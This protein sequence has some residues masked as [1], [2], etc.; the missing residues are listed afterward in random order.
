A[1][2]TT[3]Q[4]IYVR[5]LAP[6]F[7]SDAT[8]KHD[9]P[10]W[11]QTINGD[12]AKFWPVR[13]IHLV[14][15]GQKAA[16]YGAW[17]ATFVSKG[18]IKGALAYHDTSNGAPSITVYAGT[19]DYYGYDNSVS[20]THELQEEAVDPFISRMS[21]GWPYDYFWLEHPDGSITQEQ[22]YA[23]GWF[24]EVSDPVEADS[25]LIGDVKISDFITPAWFNEGQSGV[26]SGR[27]D[28]MG[29]CQQPFWIRPGGY[30]QYFDLSQGWVAVENFR[31]AGRDAAGF[32]LIE[33]TSK[34]G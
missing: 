22:V 9:I 10:A 30:A 25:Y 6:Q 21:S 11:D 17:E 33:K 8:I 27:Y 18:P 29:L 31:H 13:R 26:S 7:I 32:Y 5:N 1:A 14:F 4:T 24:A 34:Q 15:I 16:P 3:A 2:P 23:V 28:F 12:V 20:M 19:G